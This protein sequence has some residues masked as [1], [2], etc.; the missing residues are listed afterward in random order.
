M[1]WFLEKCAID[2]RFPAN[3]LFT[4]EA[5]YTMEGIFNNHNAHCWAMKNP[6]EKDVVQRSFGFWLMFGPALWAITSSE[7]YHLYFHLIVDKYLIFLP[8]LLPQRLDD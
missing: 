1:Q 5:S 4:D 8:Q 6:M 7:S 3:M 2:A